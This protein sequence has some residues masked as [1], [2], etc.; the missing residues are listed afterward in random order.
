[1]ARVHSAFGNHIV[2]GFADDSMIGVEYSGDGTNVVQGAD[3]EIVRSID[4]SSLYNLKITLQQTSATNTWLQ[5]QYEKDQSGGDGTFSVNI[6]DIWGGMSFTGAA[7]WVTKPAS[8]QRGKTQQNRE[9]E[10]AV[11]DGKFDEERS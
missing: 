7:A 11:A 1:M 4:P 3:G 8:F 10:I 2:S 9:W 5:N 6:V